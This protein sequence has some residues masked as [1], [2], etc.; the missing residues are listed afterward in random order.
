MLSLD[1]KCRGNVA[2]RLACNA[3]FNLEGAAFGIPFPAHA[4]PVDGNRQGTDFSEWQVKGFRQG[5]CLADRRGDSD[6]GQLVRRHCVNLPYRD[7]DRV[8][9]GSLFP[10]TERCPQ[11]GR[12]HRFKLHRFP[13]VRLGGMGGG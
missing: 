6:R 2:R 7:G 12:G 11:R 5:G 13:F 10:S 4:P 1:R 9:I 3:A 8:E